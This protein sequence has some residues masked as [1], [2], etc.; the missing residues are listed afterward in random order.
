MKVITHDSELGPSSATVGPDDAGARL[1][2]VAAR[3]WP[4]FS[5]S[6][7]QA[8]ISGGYLTV[9]GLGAST[10]SRLVGGETLALSVPAEVL[11]AMEPGVDE[12]RVRAEPVPLGVLYEDEAITV[13]DKAA[14]LVMHPAS[15]HAGGTVMNGL[16]HRDPALRGVPRAGIVHRLDRDTSGVCVVARTLQAQTSL[17]RQLQA[18]DMGREYVAVVIG[19]PPAAG[20]VNKPIGRHPRDRKRMAVTDGGKPAVSHFEVVRPLVGAARVDV[21]LET[22]RTHQIRVHMTS[23]GHPLIGDPVYT[24]GRALAVNHRKG[25]ETRAVVDS[26]PR[27]A[28]HARRLRLI[29]P[30]SEEQMVFDSPVPDDIERLCEALALDGEQ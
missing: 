21:R 4:Q 14:G 22:G 10:K 8:W 30:V 25:T 17:V 1:D 29:H 20:T 5:R 13:L 6:R 27:Q 28:L 12:T 18:R 26:F 2:R 11:E 9:D 23:L 3:I 24:D 16:V 19:S 7:L 15:G